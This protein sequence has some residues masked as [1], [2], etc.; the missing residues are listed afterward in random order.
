MTGSSM[1]GDGSL[2]LADLQPSPGVQ[3]PSPFIG[4]G[5]EMNKAEIRERLYAQLTSSAE[6][7]F[8]DH[9][10]PA[11]GFLI[12]EKSAKYILELMDSKE[13]FA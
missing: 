9:N 5:D 7:W 10:M 11:E 13:A 1:S 6:L 4:E 8:N 3:L 2:T 12:G